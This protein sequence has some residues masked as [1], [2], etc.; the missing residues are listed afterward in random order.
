M[1]KTPPP[2]FLTRLESLMAEIAA[3]TNSFKR[4]ALI[5]QQ[6]AL[7]ANS[8]PAIAEVVKQAR[9]LDGHEDG[10]GL[11]VCC[12]AEAYLKEHRKDCGLHNALAALN[13]GQEIG[14]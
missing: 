7:L 3:E 1:H 12:G 14:G 2:D 11:M 8:A 9:E 13:A 5:Q 10:Y 6:D 4:F